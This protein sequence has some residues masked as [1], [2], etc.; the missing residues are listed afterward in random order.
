[1]LLDTYVIVL[2]VLAFAPVLMAS[3]ESQACQRLR[4]CVNN[5]EFGEHGT[6]SYVSLQARPPTEFNWTKTWGPICRTKND[7][8]SC[9]LNHGCTTNEYL[10]QKATEVRIK[11]RFMCKPDGKKLVVVLIAAAAA[12]VAV[13]VVVVVAV[14]IV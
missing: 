7:R 12:V 14:V 9:T 6:W 8:I 13:A 11:A 4:T 1:M 5:C 10:K 3:T 2:L